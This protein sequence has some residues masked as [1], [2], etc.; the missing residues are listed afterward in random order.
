MPTTARQINRSLRAKTAWLVTLHGTNPP[1]NRII[2]ILNYRMSAKRVCEIVEHLYLALEV[3]SHEDKLKFAQSAK[4]SLFKATKN[5]FQRIMCGH[6]PWLYARR[7][8]GVFIK[9]KTLVWTEPPSEGESR[10]K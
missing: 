1:E 3:P 4:A 6:N 2:S 8:T 10:N 5:V 7:V 9:D